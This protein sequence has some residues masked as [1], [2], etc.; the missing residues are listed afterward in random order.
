MTLRKLRHDEIP[1]TSPRDIGD[2]P[3]HPVTLVVDSVR[4]LYNIGS[5]FRSCDGALAEKLVLCGYTP[6]PPRREISKTALGAVDSVPWQHVP[7]V[8]D[9]LRALRREGKRIAALEL[10]AGSRSCY[11]LR[12]DDFPLAIVIGN[13]IAG[14]SREALELC[15]FALEIPMH[16]VKQSLN[17]AVA[18]GIMLFECVRVLEKQG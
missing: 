3:R 9:A 11:E 5:I 7:D 15:D 17:V 4:S 8:G 1:R 10:A 14:L 12:R 13:E 2:K 6:A 18:A 16:G